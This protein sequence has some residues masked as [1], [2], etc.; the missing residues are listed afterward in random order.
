MKPLRECY[1]SE[2]AIAD[3]VSRARHYF[4]L[5]RDYSH[6]FNTLIAIAKIRC[7]E[8]VCQPKIANF[9]VTILCGVDST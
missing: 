7:H 1:S 3:S 4:V 2:F 6:S 5:I 8:E 9:Q